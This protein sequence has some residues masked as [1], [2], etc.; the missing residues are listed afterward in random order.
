LYLFLNI[1]IWDR[2]NCEVWSEQTSGAVLWL[3]SPSQ[4]VYN[5]PAIRG[6]LKSPHNWLWHQHQLV[7][8]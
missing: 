2:R 7:Q 1:I 4:S 8:S 3:G 5:M 6:L